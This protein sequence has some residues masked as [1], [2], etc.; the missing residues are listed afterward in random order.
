METQVTFT[1]VI[2]YLLY[3]TRYNGYAQPGSKRMAVLAGFSFSL[4][5][6]C[7]ANGKLVASTLGGGLQ[8]H[9]GLISSV[10]AYERVLNLCQALYLHVQYRH[11]NTNEND[12]AS[13]V[14][15]MS[16]LFLVTA[17]WL[18]RH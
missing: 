10:A 4:E 17:P 14:Y 8:G 18:V 3:A 11:R 9:L 2:E 6:E 12:Y 7:K 16:L 13:M 15:R 1:F 5:K